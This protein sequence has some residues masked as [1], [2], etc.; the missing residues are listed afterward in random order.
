MQFHCSTLL[1]LAVAADLLLIVI[2]IH[3]ICAP[4][5]HGQ[6]FLFTGKVC[7]WMACVNGITGVRALNNGVRGDELVSSR[8][9][10]RRIK[11]FET[12]RL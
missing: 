8:D 2:V 9:K 12:T 7:D 3:V 10:G 5:E 11:N 4:L 1:G 6:A